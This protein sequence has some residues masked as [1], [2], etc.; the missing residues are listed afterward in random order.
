MIKYTLRLTERV[1]YYSFFL[2][3]EE[4]QANRK[5]DIC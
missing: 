5:D 4:L 2:S 1:G 3:L